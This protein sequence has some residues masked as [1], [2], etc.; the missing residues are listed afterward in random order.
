MSRKDFYPFDWLV[1]SYPVIMSTFILVFGRP[2]TDYLDELFLNLIVISLTLFIVHF[3]HGKRSGSSLFIR[4]LYPA[5][6][7]LL[8]YEQTGGLIKLIFNDFFDHQLTALE[9]MVFGANPTIWLDMHF[10]N[11][12]ITEILSLLYF[13]FY[14]MIYIYFLVL[15]FKKRY[16]LIKVSMTAVCL[17][18]FAS[19][20]LFFLYPIEGPRYHFV[21]EYTNEITGPVFRPL[22]E[23][24]QRGAVH[25]GCMPSTHF[26]V[27]LV[28]MIFCL[29]YFKKAGIILIPVVTGLALGTFYGRYHYVSDVIVG[30]LIALASMFVTMR[31]MNFAMDEESSFENKKKKVSYVS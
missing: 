10:I 8:F 7:F 24:A 29:I 14:P 4:L 3:F 15:F 22:V 31:F 11:V 16:Q 30:G 13:A 5:M 21:G 25:G 19:F 28:I 12:W 27:A 18:F 26:G 1:I 6:L 17:T 20:P 2:L 9:A 23:L